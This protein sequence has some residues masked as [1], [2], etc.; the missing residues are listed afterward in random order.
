MRRYTLTVL[1]KLKHG[2]T[3]L[4]ENYKH[5]IVYE[6]SSVACAYAG[7][8]FVKKGDLKSSDMLEK[9]QSVIFLKHG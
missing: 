8:L 4:K 2:D 9:R 3:F 1:E 5:E 7:M 6:V